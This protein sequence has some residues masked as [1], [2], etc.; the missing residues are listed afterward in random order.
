[1]KVYYS[2][3]WAIT[4]ITAG[5][6]LI[7]LNYILFN[8][9]GKMEAVRI[10]PGFMVIGVGILYLF[11]PYF[12]LQEKSLVTFSLLGFVA[13]RYSI[14]SV[15]DLF[16]EG[17]KLFRSKNGKL[18]RIRISRFVCNKEQWERLKNKI[19]KIEP[20]NELHD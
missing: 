14:N 7:A 2:K 6:I 8:L 10:I 1:M 5:G 4:F 15:S 3:G 16:F 12:E 20:G 11:Q 18:K 19:E 17:D 13:W 9:T